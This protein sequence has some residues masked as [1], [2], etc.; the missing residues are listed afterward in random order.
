MWDGFPCSGQRLCVSLSGGT[1]ALSEERVRI[2]PPR[3]GGRLSVFPAE[4]PGE[5]RA[6]AC[7]IQTLNQAGSPRP[8]TDGPGRLTAW[9]RGRLGEPSRGHSP[10][11]GTAQRGPSRGQVSHERADVDALWPPL[12]PGA[13]WRPPH[14]RADVLGPLLRGPWRRL[15]AWVRYRSREDSCVAHGVVSLGT[16]AA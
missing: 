6:E 13:A 16:E 3:H 11:P 14:E 8:Q 9:L 2:R 10:S 12:S 5:T 1:P 4:G 7:A 15:V